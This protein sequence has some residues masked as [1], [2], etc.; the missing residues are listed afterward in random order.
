MASRNVIPANR[1]PVV[2]RR[3]LPAVTTV[4]NLLTR[5]STRSLELKELAR[6]RRA[7]R[8]VRPQL[9]LAELRGLSDILTV[10]RR[11]NQQEYDVVRRRG[12]PTVI[13]RIV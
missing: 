2:Q 5:L 4:D 10:I 8:V 12:R 9:D 11:A 13:T 1:T 6:Q 7:S 3:V